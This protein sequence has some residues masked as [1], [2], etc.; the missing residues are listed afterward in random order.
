MAQVG[1]RSGLTAFPFEADSVA[2]AL[3]AAFLAT[4]RDPN[5]SRAPREAVAAALN[6]AGGRY[7][8]VADVQR[9]LFKAAR[10]NSGAASQAAARIGSA[11]AE[12][13][14]DDCGSVSFE[15]LVEAMEK[16]WE[17]YTETEET[18]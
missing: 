13:A 9:S 10:D 11:P 12:C 18:K 3:R 7:K 15:D 6:A 1:G 17:P 5:T 2:D 14:T 8:W 4:P 16:A